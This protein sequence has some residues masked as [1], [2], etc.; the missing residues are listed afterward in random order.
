MRP[1]ERSDSDWLEEFKAY[2]ELHGRMPRLRTHPDATEQ[3]KRLTSWLNR[4]QYKDTDPGPERQQVREEVLAIKAGRD[5]W[6]GHFSSLQDFAAR[7]GRLPGRGDDTPLAHWLADQRSAFRR[8][9]L[10]PERVRH[11]GT[12]PGALP[13]KPLTG[14]DLAEATW[15]GFFTELQDWAGRNGRMPRR[16]STDADEY[17]LAN[18]LNRQVVAYR[19]GKLPAAWG[20]RLKRAGALPA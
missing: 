5:R 20:R 3:D 17:R 1:H 13:E 14:A 6:S 19:A 7:H 8:G 10:T 11:L 15:N 9:V 16:R 2:L 4:I 18:W 12:V